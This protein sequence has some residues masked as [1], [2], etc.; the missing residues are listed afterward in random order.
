M[1][2][3]AHTSPWY[4]GGVTVLELPQRIDELGHLLRDVFI[5]ASDAEIARFRAGL[6]RLQLEAQDLG[7]SLVFYLEPLEAQ[8]DA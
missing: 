3:D 5:T 6:I 8:G 1:V 2:G 7:A 4:G